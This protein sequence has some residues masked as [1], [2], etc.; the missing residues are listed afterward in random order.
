MQA[1]EGIGSLDDE[2]TFA[3]PGA[4][5]EQCKHLCTGSSN[6]IRFLLGGIISIMERDAAIRNKLPNAVRL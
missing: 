6:V 4:H 5:M 1:K 2:D 3:R